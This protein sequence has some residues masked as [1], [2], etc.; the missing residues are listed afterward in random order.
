MIVDGGTMENVI[1]SDMVITGPACPIFIR[2]GNRG[3][4]FKPDMERPGVGTMRNITISNIKATTDHPRGCVIAGITG[5]R[6]EKLTL[7]N[8]DFTFPGGGTEGDRKR[9]FDES[10]GKYPNPD[11]YRWQKGEEINRLPAFGLFFWHVEDLSLENV[12]LIT[13]KPDARAAIVLEDASNVLIDGKAEE[14]EKKYMLEQLDSPI[15]LRGSDK[16]AYRDPAVLYHD[17]TFYLFPTTIETE[18]DGRIYLYT[19]VSTSRD[20]KSWSKPKII[21]PKGQDLNYSSPGNIV[22]FGNEWVL[23]LQTYP[24]PDYKRGD[25]LCWGNLDARVWIMRSKDLVHWSDPEL[26]QV[27][28]ADVPRE[29]MGRMID[30]YLIQDRDEPGRWWCFYK[31]NG[32]SFSWSHDLKNWTY[33][34]QTDSGENVCVL[35]DRDE[36]LLFHSPGNGIGMKRSPD[37]KQWRD[38]GQLITLGQ[39][40]WTWAETRLTAGCV[41]DLRR[42]PAIG[43]YLMFFHGVGPGKTRT[44]DNAYANCSIGIA[45]SDDLT[46]WHWPGKS[47]TQQ[48]PASDVLQAASEK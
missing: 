34:G 20:L 13:R 23:C 33:G 21:T 48:S 6:I 46:T 19:S 37:L 28:G 32:V 17:K 2:L 43:K 9:Q 24:I 25:K 3:R 16:T 18:Q 14:T 35:V 31:Q 4:K 12:K 8:I 36:Y 10:P 40:D 41:V 26:L 22:R 45:W 29:K 27:K 7:K 39:K 47:A 44:V 1:V 15:L 38:V 30:P 11:M 5:H 42:E